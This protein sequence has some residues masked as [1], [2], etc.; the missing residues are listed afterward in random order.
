MAESTKLIDYQYQDQGKLAGASLSAQLGDQGELKLEGVDYGP[1][2]EVMLGDS[3]YEYWLNLETADKDQLLLALLKERFA[4]PG[5]SETLSKYT[6]ISAFKDWLDQ[7][8]IKYH[9]QSY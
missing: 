3:D 6:G 9:Y 8:G 2:A 1:T 4:N 7:Q 5:T